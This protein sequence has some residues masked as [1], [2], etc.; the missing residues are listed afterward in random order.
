MSFQIRSMFLDLFHTLRK[1]LKCIMDILFFSVSICQYCEDLDQSAVHLITQIVFS[2]SQK[3][4]I[5]IA[6]LVDV[7]DIGEIIVICIVQKQI[8]FMIP[9]NVDCQ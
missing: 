4:D 3:L 7:N 5:P 2:G 6:F 9:V 1:L 8:E